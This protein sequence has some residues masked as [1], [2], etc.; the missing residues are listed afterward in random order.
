M[1]QDRQPD[2]SP[3]DDQGA[4]R[5]RDRHLRTKM[6]IRII[7]TVLGI[8]EILLGIRFILKLIA[9]NPNNAFAKFIY[10]ISRLFVA[11]FAS[12]TISPVSDGS[13]LE[14]TTLFAM[15]VYA[16]LFWIIYRFVRISAEHPA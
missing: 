5:N 7:W 1:T 13:I 6:V 3:I 8:L 16:L 15:A 4:S 9:A 10:N 12:L 11:P 2:F 14:V